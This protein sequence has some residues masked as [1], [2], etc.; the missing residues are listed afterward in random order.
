MK[1]IISIAMAAIVAIGSVIMV[2]DLEAQPAY[3][4][5]YPQPQ[6]TTGYQY[7]PA[8]NTATVT[9]SVNGTNVICGTTKGLYGIY[10]TN[11]INAAYTN[12]TLINVGG[13]KD[14]ALQFNVNLIATNAT[15]VN[16]LWTLA[17]SVSG[18]TPTNQTGAPILLEPFAIVTNTVPVNS[19]TGNPTVVNMSSLPSTP[20]NVSVLTSFNDGAIPYIYVF[21]VAP[22]AGTVTNATVYGTSL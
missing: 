15:A 2:K 3:S 8:I 22:S 10:W 9:N 18:G 7:N 20:N 16:V 4:S 5:G 13:T 21:S 1:K 6:Y 12:L 11:S 17:R 14:T 19:T